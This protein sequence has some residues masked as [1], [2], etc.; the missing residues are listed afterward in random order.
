LGLRD[1]WQ[2][3]DRAT[4]QLTALLDQVDEVVG[5]AGRDWAEFCSLATHMAGALRAYR[6]GDIQLEQDCYEL[7]NECLEMLDG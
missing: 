2:L 3:L 4:G 1:N 7:I 6:D 5:L